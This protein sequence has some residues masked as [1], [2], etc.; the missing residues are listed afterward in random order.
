MLKLHQ[1][2]S[3]KKAKEEPTKQNLKNKIMIAVDA[4]GGD[5]APDVAV[6]GAFNAVEKFF[7]LAITL[8]GN[9]MLLK[10]CYMGVIAAGRTLPITIVD[11]STVVDMGDEPTR[12]FSQ[13]RDSSFFRAL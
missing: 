5:F 8:F 3:A 6:R 11:C 9:A 12:R 2:R 13:K 1:V 10:G 4:M 7:R